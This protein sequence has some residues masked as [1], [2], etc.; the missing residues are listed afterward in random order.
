MTDRRSLSLWWDCL[1]EHEVVRT[2][3]SLDGP[4]RFDIVIVGAGF[5]GLWSA[6][7]LSRR[8]PDLR[9]A[10]LEAR[11]AGFGASG[12]NGGWCSGLLPLGLDTVA[13]K[14]GRAGALA[15]QRAAQDSVDEV[16]AVV[17]AEG[18]DARFAKG[19][20]LR[21]ARSP[22]Q[23][24]RLEAAL[25]HERSWEQT[26]DD[27]TWLDR[28]AARERLRA[29][30][31]FGALWT[32]HC[33]AV[34]P[35][36]LVRGLL[37]T[38]ERA[39]VTVFEG[40]PVTRVGPH[41]ACTPLGDVRADIVVQATE[42]YT[43]TLAG[44]RR[45]LLP[46][47]S[48]VIATEPLPQSFWDEVGWAHRDTFNDERRFIVY[49]QRTADDRIV[50]GGRGAP[51]HLGSRLSPDFDREPAVHDA[52]RLSLLEFFPQ[53]ADAR[54]SHRW[55][56]VLGIPR[57]WWPSVVH[58]PATGVITA[59]GYAGDGVALTNLAGRTVAA[60]IDGQ[61]SGQPGP[62]DDTLLSLPWV[63]HRSPPWEPEPLRWLGI[64]TGRVLA[65]S[66]DASELRQGRPA[67]LRDSLMTRLTGH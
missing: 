33:A 55:G 9:I 27:V 5:T 34:D 59:G 29:D 47:Y 22:L 11:T 43:P 40:T 35:A 23:V 18:I 38:V 14:S 16:G 21:F 64:N 53:L 10:V 2:R 60:I 13:A 65:R 63:G 7:Y 44:Q 37:D 67:R 28:D 17:T 39:G 19:G 26:E 25:R 12:R 20:Y 4:A 36:R 66:I 49:A 1:P 30:G 45:R 15:M 54:I 46:I 24:E 42:G 6:Y 56:G 8:R 62:G 3:P 41:V 48:M 52:L 57:D 58:D 61:V 32:R 31:V 51:Y 50:F